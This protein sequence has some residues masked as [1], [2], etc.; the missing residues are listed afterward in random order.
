[1]DV[2]RLHDQRNVFVVEL[3][4][5]LWSL[6]EVPTFDADEPRPLVRV[7]RRHEGQAPHC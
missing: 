2:F 4:R 7:D 5:I 3:T 1:M 6:C